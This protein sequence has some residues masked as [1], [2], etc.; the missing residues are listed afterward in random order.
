[1]ANSLDSSFKSSG[2]SISR[3]EV[4]SVQQPLHREYFV[5]DGSVTTY[6]LNRKVEVD[7][8]ASSSIRLRV[9]STSREYVLDNY[10]GDASLPNGGQ[11]YYTAPADPAKESF[12]GSGTTVT[13]FDGDGTTTTFTSTTPLSGR[14]CLLYTSPSPRDSDSSRMPSSA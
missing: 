6:P 12:N 7:V 3:V 11:F 2:F 9:D 13:T 10:V 8:V 4:L 1:M 5:S 14:T